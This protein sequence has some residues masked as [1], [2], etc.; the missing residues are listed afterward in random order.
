MKKLWLFLGTILLAGAVH[1][2]GGNACDDAANKLKDCSIGT[3]TSQT[4]GTCDT[5]SECLAK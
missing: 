4:N 3:Q 5:Q 2:C 1:A